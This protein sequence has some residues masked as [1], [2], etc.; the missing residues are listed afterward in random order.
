MSGS[1]RPLKTASAG[2]V[3]GDGPVAPGLGIRALTRPS[4]VGLDRRALVGAAALSVLVL[5]IVLGLSRAD[6]PVGTPV[7]HSGALART[8]LSNTAS[9]GL[10]SLPAAARGPVSQ[11]LG[12]GSR[13]YRASPMA[14]GFQV[15]NGPQ[16]LHVRFNQAGVHVG[17]HG[18]QLTFSTRMLGRGPAQ[19]ALKDVAPRASANRVTYAHAQLSEWYVNGPLGLEQGFTIARPPARLPATASMTL[20]MA[21]TGNAHVVLSPGSQSITFSR[22]G[23]RS[24]R[25]YD[26]T[27]T[28]ATGRTLHSWLTLHGD[29]VTL[30]LDTAGAQYP[31]T[32]D[33]LIALGQQL[34]GT[35]EQGLGRFGFSVALSADGDTALVGAPRDNDFAGAAWVFARSGATWVQQGPKLTGQEAS[36]EF[37]EEQC[38]EEEPG[39]EGGDCG[40]GASVAL[41][42]DGDTALIGAPRG[43]KNH[44]AAWVFARSG[45]TWSL[46]EGLSGA[47]EARGSDHFGRAVA[48]SS[49]GDIALIGSPG[50]SGYRGAVWTFT[51]SES[52]SWSQLGGK[53]TASGD[54]GAGHFGRSLALSPDGGTAVIGAPGDEEDVGAAWA[55]T[56][57]GASWGQGEELAASG[58]IGKGRFGDSIALSGND[59]TA[60][61]SGRADDGDQGAVWAFGREGV[62]W[63]TG[64]KLTAGSGATETREFGRSV[65]LSGDGELALIGAPHSASHRGQVWVFTRS[66][67]AW[68]AAETLEPLEAGATRSFGVSA[69]L[70]SSG[71]SALIGTPQNDERFGSVWASGP[72]VA[73]LPTVTGISPTSGPDGGGTEV[74]IQGSGFVAGASV[75]IGSAASAV[76]V[77]SETEI[78][79]TTSR[80]PAGAHEVVVTDSNGASAGGPSFTYVAPP[81]PVVTSVSPTSGPAGGGTKVTILGSGFVAGASVDI[82]SAASAVDVVSETEI[83]ATTSPGLPGEDEVVVTDAN[84]SSSGG[85]RYA[86][87]ESTSS[88]GTPAGTGTPSG[89]ARSGVLGA[90]TV[91]LPP[92]Q[93][94][95]TANL[96]SFSGTVLVKLPGSSSFVALS[97]ISQIPFATIID[98][99]HGSVT[100]TTILPNGTSQTITLYSGEFKLTQQ[101]NGTVLITLEGGNFSGCPTAKERSHLA[102]TSSTHASGNHVVRKL[103]A[104][105]HGKYTTKGNYASGAVQGTVWLTEDLCDGTSIT[106]TRDSVLV[107][108]LVNHKHFLIKAGH[109]YLA[110]AP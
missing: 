107:T 20:S 69:A 92:P 65:A 82:G 108:N 38:V 47:S 84:G 56:R 13:S 72:A 48:L 106:V 93:L 85:P 37:G 78:V 15:V 109:H 26:L 98:A 12:A 60:L 33:P 24:L 23:A 80:T 96:I 9:A 42:A 3:R 18:L 11:A 77:V 86:Y 70:S 34:T 59:D 76:D 16:R 41:S 67:A 81:R 99:T 89:T 14:G 55:F 54:V 97:S 61:V 2:P 31:L 43:N 62:S 5:V 1:L 66:G 7:A 110:K 35:G 46:Q 49:S 103:W 100:I 51:R 94:D 64:E 28:D 25:Y 68:T 73:P 88:L 27:A 19:Q 91:A 30:H 50:D 90:T 17:S 71:T 102:R 45:S 74:T 39:E 8:G 63:S 58:E 83:I 57:A 10:T 6:A 22:P 87:T 29:T 36:L 32:V 21:V 101:R 40:F 4:G 75:D 95:M 104:N 53:L 79:A 44:G 105:G 52:G